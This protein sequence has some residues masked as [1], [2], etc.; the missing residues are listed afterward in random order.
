M[1]EAARASL[2]DAVR[3]SGLL[4]E[5]SL[6]ALCSGGADSTGLLAGLADAL[7]AGRVV[8]M[9]L[10]YGLRPDSGADEAACAAACV[11][12]GVELVVERP[13][14]PAA[15]NLQANAREARYR[16]A[17]RLR[18]ARG[19]ELI[20]TGH[21][22]T[23]VAETVLYRLAASPGRRALL[24]LPARR[25]RV[26]RPLLGFGREQ[27]RAWVEAAGLPFRDDPSNAEPAFARN[28]IRDEVLPVLAELAPAAEATI[29][30]TRAELA[31]EAQ[32]LERLAAEVLESSG[33]GRSGRLDAEALAALDPALARL[34]LRAL[35][36]RAAGGPVAL[37]RSRA[38]AIRR[39]ARSPE[40]GT[41]EL[42]GGV[43]ARVEGGAVCFAAG[44]DA[45][46]AA[47]LL[48]VPGSCRFGEWALRAELGGRAGAGDASLDPSSL[49]EPL[50]VRAWRPGDRMRPL[51]LGGSKSLQDIFGDRKV[52]RSQRRRVPVVT[53]AGRIAWIA[54]IAVSEEFAAV[55]RSG[56]VAVLS[57]AA[58]P[59]TL[60]AA[61]ERTAG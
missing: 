59:G 43:E 39:L 24:G 52:P 61:G 9:H 60:P 1:T 41:I 10:N 3:S 28:R 11:E 53:S 33:A 49:A 4:G 51:G 21:T 14:L 25:G 22:R 45:E 19:L 16:A 34:A 12:L 5:G 58:P 37:G 48:S 54:G 47:A 20:A 29:A 32:T 55:G 46:P 57:A 26:V 13:R 17:A 23:D 30:E 50:V 31:E 27:V 35:A 56:E 8:A 42:G 40:G 18:A 15:G 38:A 36:E 6:L 44:E 2:A 7:G